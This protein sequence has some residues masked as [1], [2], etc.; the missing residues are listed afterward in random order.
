MQLVLMNRGK[1]QEHGLSVFEQRKKLSFRSVYFYFFGYSGKKLSTRWQDFASNCWSCQQIHWI[2]HLFTRIQKNYCRDV[3]R[4]VHRITVVATWIMPLLMLPLVN[5][6]AMPRL[7]VHCSICWSL[8]KWYK[9][10]TLSILPFLALSSKKNTSFP[11]NK[12]FNVRLNNIL[13]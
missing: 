5:A 2:G 9:S 3:H 1:H 11:K 8:G 7:T 12:S 10:P 13:F 4:I 6:K